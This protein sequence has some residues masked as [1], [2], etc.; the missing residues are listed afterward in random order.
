MPFDRLINAVDRWAFETNRAD[1]FAQIGETRHWPQYMQAAP[2]LTPAQFEQRMRL[3]TGIVAHAGTGTIIAALRLNKPLLVLPRE[4][5][6]GET[7]NDHQ[8]ATAKH[9][10]QA[11]H[12]LAAYDE[13]QLIARMSELETFQPES[14]IESVASESLLRRL[15]EFTFGSLEPAVKGQ[16]QQAR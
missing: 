9:F 6:R 11:G 13:Q 15:R 1:V 7:R 14:T 10:E 8:I 4:S 3:A 12:V 16:P 2:F 5:S